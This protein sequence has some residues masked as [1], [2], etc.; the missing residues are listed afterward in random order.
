MIFAY[1]DPGAGSLL[2]QALIAGLVAIPIFFRR[3]LGR[4]IGAVRRL[5][6]SRSDHPTRDGDDAAPGA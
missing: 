5:G 4:A 1:I 2:I 3:Q 6:G